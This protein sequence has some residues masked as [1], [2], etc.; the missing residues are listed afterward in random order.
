MI[1]AA[2]AAPTPTSLPAPT[3]PATI[4]TWVSFFAFTLASPSEATTAVLPMLACTVFKDTTTPSTPATAT[5]CVA[6]AA[7]TE[8]LVRSCLPSADTLTPLP[9]PL[10][11]TLDPLPM[12]AS[13]SSL[14]TI[15]VLLIPTPAFLAPATA[16]LNAMLRMSE[17]A[18]TSTPSFSAFGV[19]GTSSGW[20]A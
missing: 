14:F 4:T 20:L 8:T 12:E 18:D 17:R 15:S 13:V 16:P 9:A 10:E 6:A 3:P 7:L 2:I 11:A 5:P 1:L 19:P